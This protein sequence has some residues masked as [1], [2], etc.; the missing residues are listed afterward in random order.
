MQ[1]VMTCLLGQPSTLPAQVIEYVQRL[2]R[3]GSLVGEIVRVLAE[4][5]SD[6]D[7]AEPATVSPNSAATC[8]SPPPSCAQ[9]N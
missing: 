3:D 7:A 2:A 5:L 8:G 6:E 1:E 9:S 4:R